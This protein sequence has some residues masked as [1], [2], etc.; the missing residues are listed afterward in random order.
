MKLDNFD[1]VLPGLTGTLRIMHMGLD[2]SLGSTIDEGEVLGS[3][4]PNGALT[5]YREIEHDAATGDR[6]FETITSF[7]GLMNAAAHEPLNTPFT[8]NQAMP[9]PVAGGG[10][11]WMPA[12]NGLSVDTLRPTKI[13][14]RV[15]PQNYLIMAALAKYAN[16]RFYPSALNTD[17]EDFLGL[18]FFGEPQ[19]F[20]R[21]IVEEHAN[22]LL[23]V[24]QF[25][26]NPLFSTTGQMAAVSRITYDPAKYVTAV[27]A[28]LIKTA[29]A[30]HVGVTPESV[31]RAEEQVLQ[32]RTYIRL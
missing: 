5:I 22:E 17:H 31:Q 27:R 10:I 25:I 4:L 7:K 19:P 16:M 11:D 28:D 6:Q 9:V 8:G 12:D 18:P 3:Q 1:T 15:Q 32:R 21:S 23:E 20:M 13:N 2:L 14:Q 30:S 24:D 29:A 26:A